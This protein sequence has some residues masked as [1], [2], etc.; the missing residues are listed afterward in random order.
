MNDDP[1]EITTTHILTGQSYDVLLTGDRVYSSLISHL[2]YMSLIPRLPQ[3]IY[4]VYHGDYNLITQLQ[5][6]SLAMFDLMSRGMT[7][8]VVCSEDLIG[9]GPEDVAAAYDQLPDML[10]E[11]IDEQFAFDHGIFGICELWDVPES[12]PSFK[13]PLTGDLPALLLEG[14]FDP[15]TP[16]KYAELMASYLGHGY[17]YTFPGVGH[18]PVGGSRC[19]RDML[20]AF[21]EN[22]DE[23]PDDTCMTGMRVSF[24]V[25]GGHEVSAY[26]P[27]YV[28]IHGISSQIPEGW[29]EIEFTIDPAGAVSNPT[30][31]QAEPKD[32]FDEAALVAVRQWEYKPVIGE[33]GNPRELPG[34]VVRLKFS[35]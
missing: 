7:Y 10:W 20:A 18:A 2:Y 16:P 32:V 5:G 22:P 13:Q 19:A 31:I 23:P 1:I 21:I 11:E 15:V 6:T 12:D 27:V 25:P 4:D 35:L 34:I 24:V 17:V 28:E 8:S 26:E 29:V 9:Q 33:D 30:V 14:E 3:A